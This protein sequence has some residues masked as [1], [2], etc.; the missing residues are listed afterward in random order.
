[1][2]KAINIT[3]LSLNDKKKHGFTTHDNDSINDC[4]I[5]NC[6]FCKKEI[7]FENDFISTCSLCE[8]DICIDCKEINYCDICWGSFCKDCLETVK[9][10]EYM[11]CLPCKENQE[12]EFYKL[13][14]K[15]DLN[16]VKELL[17][18]NVYSQS[19]ID[20]MFIN[21]I[22]HYNIQIISLLFDRVSNQN[23]SLKLAF[24]SFIVNRSFNSINEYKV[25]KFLLANSGQSLLNQILNF[26]L[27]HPEYKYTNDIIEYIETIEFVN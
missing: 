16:S 22:F 5:G 13:V 8:L 7:C 3:N 20:I 18:I 6:E 17:N 1:M 27:G 14:L 10:E 23:V 4:E 21:S 24:N 12:I 11:Y 9:I 2:C 25:L 19:F 26:F 15:S